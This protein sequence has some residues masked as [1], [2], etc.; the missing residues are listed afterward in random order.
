MIDQKDLWNKKHADG[1]HDNF[2]R[3]PSK[4]AQTSSA[5]LQQKK[6]VLELGCGK[7][8]DSFYFLQTGHSVV[9]TDF[10]DVI[11]DANKAQFPGVTFICLDTSNP[12]PFK[13]ESIDVVFSNLSLHYFD[14]QTT[15]NIVSEIVRVLRK[16]GYVFVRCKSIDSI[17]EKKDA[18]YIGEN[19]YVRN[20]HL[21]H[22]FSKGYMEELFQSDFDTKQNEAT[23]DKYYGKVSHFIEYWGVKR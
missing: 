16:N 14:D 15:R 18:E 3:K 11:I 23:T 22:L 4:F 19:I 6:T 5:K 8:I 9:A 17:E 20:G 1:E 12:L 21:R 13:D 10:S 7:G 2:R